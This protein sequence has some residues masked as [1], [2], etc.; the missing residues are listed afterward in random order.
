[1]WDLWVKNQ[2]MTKE[3]C[4]SLNIEHHTSLLYRSN[5]NGV[6]EVKNKNIKKI[7]Q[8]M[9]KTCKDWHEMLPFTLHDYRAQLRTSTGE[10]PFSLVY[11]ME[12]VLPIEVEIPSLRILTKVKRDE[13]EWVQ[14]RLDQLNLIEEMRLE[15]LC[16]G[17]LQQKR[18]KM[19]FDKKV[20]PQNLQVGDLVLRKIMPIHTNPRGKWTPNC[21]GLYI[22]R[23]VLAG[24]ALILSTM[25]GEDLASLVNADAVKKYFP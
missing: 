16:H 22:V 23:K 5:M 7:V 10:T 24:G 21:E 9:V 14:T 18:L 25:D 8:K 15:A 1:M 13:A 12:L 3:L 6:V 11:V 20:N 19:E 2:G 4:K 17:Q